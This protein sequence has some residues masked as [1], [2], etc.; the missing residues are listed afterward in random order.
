[1]RQRWSV[2]VSAGTIIGPT[3]VHVTSKPKVDFHVLVNHAGLFCRR[4][5]AEKLV[6]EGLKIE[7]VETPAGGKYGAE[8]GYVEFVVPI[9]GHAQ[10]PVESSFCSTCFRCTP[11]G[12]FPTVLLLEELP[13]TEPFFRTIETGSII[14]SGEFIELVGRLGITGFVEG[15]TLHPVKAVETSSP[16]PTLTVLETEW[17][18]YMDNVR[19]LKRR[20]KK[21]HS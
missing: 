11:G 10:L 2:P 9:L 3:R 17:R 15:E 6:W 16:R 13:V 21:I 7:F 1:M 19:E 12:S 5:V 4:P 14:F 18:E 8:A 20:V